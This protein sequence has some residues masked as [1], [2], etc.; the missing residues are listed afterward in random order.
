VITALLR[1]F[2]YV[3]HGLL[4]LALLAISGFAILG[5]P[6]ELRLDVLPWTGATLAYILFFGALVGLAAVALAMLGRAA[7]LLLLWSLAVTVL[8]LYGYVLTQ[9]GFSPGEWRMD[10]IFVAAA[11]LSIFGPWLQMRK[12]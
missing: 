1:Y 3:F 8:L 6:A 2:S 12:A 4:A 7:I 5:N 9:Y 10:A 11:A